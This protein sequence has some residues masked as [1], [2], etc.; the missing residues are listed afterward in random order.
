MITRLFYRLF[1]KLFARRIV[2]DAYVAL[3]DRPADDEGLR[4]YARGV[5]ARGELAWLLSELA[6][7]DEA[8]AQVTARQRRD[9]LRRPTPRDAE[10]LVSAA[11]HALL[12]RP[13]DPEALAAYTHL[14]TESGDVTQF[15]A[16][17]ANS[18]EHRA[19]LVQYSRRAR[20][21]PRP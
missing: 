21:V 2:K 14:L 10:Y 3:L 6:N 11:F 17:V 1:L 16:E 15:L 19:L 5:A 18:E 4:A 13:P 12:H 9:G 7:S 8:I 20:A